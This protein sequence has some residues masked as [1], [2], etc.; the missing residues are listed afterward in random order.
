MA[1]VLAKVVHSHCNGL[2]LQAEMD[3]KVYKL[4]FLDIGLMNAICGL[5]WRI[6]QPEI[7]ASIH[8]GKE[9]ATGRALWPGC[10]LN[11]YSALLDLYLQVKAG[12]DKRIHHTQTSTW[13]QPMLHIL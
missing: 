7:P 3:D 10:C 9:G 6:R 8:G 2:P 11:H 5:N 1:R 12:L 13:P 4:L